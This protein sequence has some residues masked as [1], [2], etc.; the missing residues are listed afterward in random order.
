[1]KYLEKEHLQPMVIKEL[2]QYGF[3]VLYHDINGHPDLTVCHSNGTGF[4]VE[5]KVFDLAKSGKV[6]SSF[7]KSQIPTYLKLFDKKTFPV[8]YILYAVYDSRFEN[9]PKYGF[10]EVTSKEALFDFIDKKKSEVKVFDD[11]NYCIR[12]MIYC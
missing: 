4:M 7:S 1:M 12:N 2:G 5:L 9:V 6:K 11:F 3:Y 8:L 10:F